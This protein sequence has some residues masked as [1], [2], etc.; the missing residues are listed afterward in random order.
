MVFARKVWHVLVA[1]KD[2]LA[3]LF[4]LLFFLLLFAALSSRP[5]AAAVR[6]GALLLKLEGAVVEEPQLID[7][8]GQLLSQQAPVA[9]YR[10]RD[11]V[12][13]LRSAAGDSRIKAVVLDLSRFTGGGH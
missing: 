11:L 6:E 10:A 7:P 8:L 13:A 5:G 4:L 3:L 12:L 9:E 1:I 2:G